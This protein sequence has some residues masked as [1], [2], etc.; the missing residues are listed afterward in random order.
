MPE[1]EIKGKK[2]K[3][4][5]DGFLENPEVW[6]IEIAEELARLADV[7]VPADDHATRLVNSGSV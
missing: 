7:P 4:N 6:D 3:L 5:D 1:L 2:L